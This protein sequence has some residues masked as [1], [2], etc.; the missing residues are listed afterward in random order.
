VA[1]KRPGLV[2]D[3]ARRLADGA[4]ISLAMEPQLDISEL[5]TRREAIT[6]AI[7]LLQDDVGLLRSRLS[8]ETAEILRGP[9]GRLV[10]RIAEALK[11]IVAVTEADQSYR[12]EMR[13]C[14]LDDNRLSDITF[15]GVGSA[16]DPWAPNWTWLARWQAAGYDV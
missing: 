5:A 2:F 9:H 12:L 11:Q 3:G 16:R 1:S 15:P 10:T 7:N 4:D 8:S 6:Q 14:G 13:L